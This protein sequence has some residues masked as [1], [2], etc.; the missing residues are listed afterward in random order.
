MRYSIGDV[1][2]ML[3]ITTSALHFYEK[4]GIID[5]PKVESGRRYYKEADITRL[6]SAKKYRVMGVSVRDI[7]QQFS[8]DGMT[9]EQVLARVREKRDEAARMM[10]YYKRLVQDIDQ[11]IEI[12][13]E[14]LKTTGN[15]D[16]RHTED[17][18]WLSGSSGNR[19]PLDKNEQEFVRLWLEAMPAVSVS[20]C[21]E[22][23]AERA[24]SSLIVPADRAKD[25]GFEADNR[26]VRRIPG[27]MALHAIVVCGEEQYDNPDV[28]FKPIQAFAREHRFVQKGTMWG[29]MIFADC[30]NGVRRHYY[31]TY[32]PFDY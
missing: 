30:S 16:I 18:L 13:E 9:G 25:F 7:A 12:S 3:G 5:T 20:I 2:R 19:A 1:S 28:I 14:G 24:I 22:A 11:L 29:R 21:R 23:R 27:G 15:V 8:H 26:N 17:M 32:M 10:E 6:I 31:D 4:E